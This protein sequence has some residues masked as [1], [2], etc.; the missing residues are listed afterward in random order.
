MELK[1]PNCGETIPAA[2]IN[3]QKTLAVCPE[4]S[5]VFNFGDDVPARKRKS[6]KVHQ[7]DRLQVRD[8]GSTLHMHYSR[9]YRPDDKGGIGTSAL[10]TL[11]M[12]FTLVS[13]AGGGAPVGLLLMLTLIALG[14]L[15]TTAALLL[16]GAR[17]MADDAALLV[18]HGP[19]PLPNFENNALQ[20]EDVVRVFADETIASKEK[21]T[22]EQRYYHV[23]AELANGNRV[24]LLKGLPHDYA[25]YIAQE[26]DAYWRDNDDAAA[27]TDDDAVQTDAD[28]AH[29]LAADDADSQRNTTP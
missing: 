19:L 16:H 5:H 9:V 29:L 18:R 26:L 22:L 7:P 17:I 11:V 24:I 8:D 3:I 15:Y 13:A 28:V 23:C 25:V 4:C 6:R 14:G 21:G 2:N 20:R 12:I 1:C 10:I 27:L